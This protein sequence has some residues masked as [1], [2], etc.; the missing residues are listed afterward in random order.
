MARRFIKL[1][2]QAVLTFSRQMALTLGK[3]INLALDDFN[4]FPPT[5]TAISNKRT[6][7]LPS[8]RGEFDEP[9]S[10]TA[11][12][13]EYRLHVNLPRII[14]LEAEGPFP[15]SFAKVDKLHQEALDFIEN[16]PP[17]YRFE[18]PDTSY[19]AKFT[20]LPA[21]RGNLCIMTWLFVLLLHRTYLFSSSRSRTEIVK[22][23][24]NILHALQR[25]VYHLPPNQRR[26][27]ALSFFGVEASISAL[28]ILTAYPRENAVLLPQALRL[29]KETYERFKSMRDSNGFAGP[30]ADVILPLLIRA[31]GVHPNAASGTSQILGS[32]IVMQQN[33]PNQISDKSSASRT[34]WDG[35]PTGNGFYN[36]QSA[37]FELPLL[38]LDSFDE[39]DYGCLAVPLHPT[40]DMLYDGLSPV[41][42]Q[43]AT[44]QGNTSG[45]STENRFGGTDQG[46]IPRQFTG[47]FGQHFFWNFVNEGL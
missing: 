17:I 11:R 42:D 28:A 45:S 39:I 16:L 6:T 44:A 18:N 20:Y 41:R 19:D 15:K 30:G 38:P 24:I 36:V 32:Q 31:E 12:L 4:L 7:T 29:V 27:F 40:A 26:L 37:S 14:A 25:N 22:A 5:D 10:F 9:N 23:S 34:S 47:T 35:D 3:S 46:G 2:L 13:I 21:Q 33:A 1:T 8:P 43:Y